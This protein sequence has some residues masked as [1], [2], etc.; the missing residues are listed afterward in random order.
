MNHEQLT[1]RIQDFENSY[2]NGRPQGM[3]WR[4]IWDEIKAISAAFKGVRFPTRQEHQEAWEQFQSAVQ[5]VKERQ[6]EEREENEKKT[7]RS[8]EHKWHIKSLANA[9]T[10]PSGLADAIFSIFTF[11]AQAIADVMTALLPGG[12]IDQ[13]KGELQH[14][15]KKLEEGWNYFKEHKNE[16]F[17][18]DKDEAFNSLKSA[19]DQLNDAW[20]QWKDGKDNLIDKRNEERERKQEEYER[21]KGE[22]ES[23]MRDNIATLEERRTKLELALERRKDRRGDL[24][25]KRDSARSDSFRSVVEGWIDENEEAISEIERKLSNLNDWIDE[26]YDKLKQ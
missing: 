3:K 14:Y 2:S 8:D 18:N 7:K 10:P 26:A 11:P 9:G 1:R 23:R 24:E 12:P 6:S 5:N 25:D 16:M 19:Q 17:R 20:E 13:K 22:W 21:K 4:Q 15:S